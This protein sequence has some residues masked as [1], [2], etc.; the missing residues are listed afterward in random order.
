M[1]DLLYLLEYIIWFALIEFPNDFYLIRS[2]ITMC[3]LYEDTRI[4]NSINNKKDPGT[5]TS[6]F[7]SR[8]GTIASQY[9]NYK[10]NNSE[11]LSSGLKISDPDRLSQKIRNTGMYKLNVRSRL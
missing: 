9:R 3:K 4:L 6:Q 11:N 5:S 7:V 1:N 8:T 2:E 10:H